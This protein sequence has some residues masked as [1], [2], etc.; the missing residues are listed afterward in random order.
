M[1]RPSFTRRA[2]LPFL[3]AF[4]LTVA[5]AMAS[6]KAG[7]PGDTPLSAVARQPFEGTVGRSTTGLQQGSDRLDGDWRGR[8]RA[9]RSGRRRCRLR[10]C[11][12]RGGSGGDRGKRAQAGHRTG[13]DRHLVRLA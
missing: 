10:S 3:A 8:K 4:G 2:V 11:P 5:A 9:E 13:D 1:V 6:G 7:K 12:L